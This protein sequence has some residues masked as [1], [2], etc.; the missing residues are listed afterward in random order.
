MSFSALAMSLIDHLG[1]AG[2]ALAV[3]LNGLSVPG[4]SE[5][6]LPLAGVAVKQGRLELWA[7]LV[8]AGVAQLAGLSLAYWIGRR[9]GL[10]LIERYG[11]YILITQHELRS[12][13]AAF[14]RRGAWLVM[15]GSFIPGLQGLVGYIAGV[16]E[17]KYRRFLP[18]VLV[19]KAVWIG[20]LVW[21]GSFLGG[22]LE[23]IDRSI[24]Q[25][26]LVVLVVMIGAGVWY[27]RRHQRRKTV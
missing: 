7:L 26:G 18:A 8:V 20:G 21:L 9:G 25:V 4:L 11:K 1:L 22:H 17:M 15:V 5:V 2:I 12:A 16:A 14:E 6:V 3:F 27:I 23:L 10:P 24:K 13:H 19:G